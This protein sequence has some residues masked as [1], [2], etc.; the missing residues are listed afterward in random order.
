M[1]SPRR[2]LRDVPLYQWV[3]PVYVVLGLLWI[4]GSDLA[5]SWF[6]G[7]EPRALLWVSSIKGTAFVVLTGIAFAV[8]LRLG[9]RRPRTAGSGSS[10]AD[11]LRWM[12]LAIMGLIGTL[13][14]C[15]AA[16]SLFIQTQA[17][18]EG[19]KRELKAA[20]V[21]SAAEIAGQ[22]RE[23]RFAVAQLANEP[24]IVAGIRGS[25]SN[26]GHAREPGLGEYLGRVRANRG[27][28]R[29]EL[30]SRSDLSVASP[31][32]GA[33]ERAL[34]QAVLRTN[35]TQW[36]DTGSRP[37]DA[38]MVIAA[39]VDGHADPD[40]STAAVLVAWI[41]VLGQLDV[42]TTPLPEI[43]RTA[44]SFLVRRDGDYAV[45]LYPARF[46][47]VE[48][49]LR[50]TPVPRRAGLLDAV[51]TNGKSM[52]A[53]LAPVPDSNWLVMATIDRAEAYAALNAATIAGALLLLAVFLVLAGVILRWNRLQET[54]L[55]EAER[56]LA[57]LREHFLVATRYAND[58]ILLIDA[59]RKILDAN[60][61]VR[62]IYGLDPADLKGQQVD[63]LRTPG[64][65]ELSKVPE[66][67]EQVLRAET[68]EFETIHRRANG[69][70]FPVEVS[71]RRFEIQGRTL[72]QSV[73]RDVSRRKSQERQL[74]LSEERIR[75]VIELSPFPALLHAEDGE[76]IL[77]S[78]TWCELSGYSRSQLKTIED[79]TALAYGERRATVKSYIDTLYRLEQRVSEGDYRITTRSGE[80][81]TW[82]FSSA[83]VGCL[84]DGRRLALS[85]AMD[86]TD[87]RRTET[88]L[89]S[90]EERYRNLFEM[91]VDGILLLGPDQQILDANSAAANMLGY[92]RRALPGVNLSTLL[93]D[94]EQASVEAATRQ[95]MAG[96][97]YRGEWRHRRKDGS[98]FVGET[99]ACAVD[100][101]TYLATIRDLT[102]RI[103]AQRQLR[104]HRDLNR[105]LAECNQIIVRA[106]DEETLIREVL[107]LAVSN[108]KFL[109]AWLACLTDD[110]SLTVRGFAGQDK[111]FV[112]GLNLEFE[113][114]AVTEGE[115]PM[116]RALRHRQTTVSNDFLGDARTAHWHDEASR[117]GIRSSAA[118][119]L[120]RSGR[121]WGALALYADSTSFFDD[122]VIQ[123][124]ESMAADISFALDSLATR[125]A[126]EESNEQLESRV[127]ER[128]RELLV[129]KN[130][131]ETADRAKTVFLSSVSHELRSPLHSIIG[132]TSLLQEG[133][134][135]PLAELQQQH[136]AI[137]R[138]ASAHLLDIINDL[139]DITRIETGRVN[140]TPAVFD[141][142]VTM[143]RLVD[144]FMLTAQRKKLRFDASPPESPLHVEAD[145]RRVEQILSNLLDNAFKYTSEGCVCFEVEHVDGHIKVHVSDTG[146]GIA[147]EDQQRIFKRFTQLP[148]TDKS[149]I[150]GTG[151][152]LAVASGLAQAMGA[153]VEIQSEVGSGST[154]TL[155][156]PVSC[157]SSS[158][159]APLAAPTAEN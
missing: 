120:W 68:Y 92:E 151:L 18:E 96:V 61:R 11:R 113:S 45:P 111:G 52:L 124:I 135:G 47:G 91:A 126:L 24:F 26:P 81:R 156:M 102:D 107:E 20:A 37:A 63:V 23:N 54:S 130:Q 60:E 41:D 28:S 38:T 150:E 33:T 84:E 55:D 149:L 67:F 2:R 114:A 30:L 3:P 125:Q 43:G 121:L 109:F 78:N 134:G 129:A 128:T 136:L 98:R 77:A 132:Y 59:D 133:L 115:S 131:A 36:I 99:T 110:G 21:L 1:K 82:D 76:I 142:A 83:P 105:L 17:V 48:E 46:N 9:A 56:A 12:H 137:V 87:R 49:A 10:A 73:I 106:D 31:D 147:A 159:M 152:G 53:V 101:T 8:A 118:V 79:W 69:V 94:G 16:F 155:S 86:V 127:A 39:P 14:V 64:S 158:S 117:A 29:L 85:M 19:R 7:D 97:R 62:D 74:K 144:R 93:D 34:A 119:P 122:A 58:A 72:I 35:E 157:A 90:S 40:Q 104:R 88:A 108:A 80:I 143:R 25:L 22:I 13:L 71:S 44:E 66:Q 112:Q 50:L 141:L 123:V 145:E 75:L 32:V 42:R 27:Y 5:L 116:G 146:P 95:I 70:E 6:L 154:F 15:L 153:R 139:L 65:A 4:G 51:A 57:D 148:R 103:E 140:I 100:D 89:L 138:D